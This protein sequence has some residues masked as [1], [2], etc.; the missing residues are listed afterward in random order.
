[1]AQT[2]ALLGR[3]DAFERHAPLDPFTHSAQKPESSAPPP[4]LPAV[5]RAAAS[6]WSWWGNSIDDVMSARTAGAVAI[7]IGNDTSCSYYQEALPHADH[8]VESLSHLQELLQEAFVL[9]PQPLSAA[10]GPAVSA[11]SSSRV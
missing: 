11:S 5:E 8:A 6:K 2:V 4:H 3:A 10:S 1:M 9:P 7:L